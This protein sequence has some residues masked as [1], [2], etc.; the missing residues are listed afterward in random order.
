MTIEERIVQLGLNNKN[1]EKN[2]EQSIRTLDQLDK[3]LRFTG[4]SIGLDKVEGML[5]KISDR[6]SIM[7][8][9]GD[10][11]IR[12]LTNSVMDLV[13][14]MGQLAKS[15]SLDQVN[16][17]FT[18]YGQKTS[19]VQ[20]IM[21]A[22]AK[23][24]GTKFAD[25]AE[26]MDFVNAQL[27][28]LNWFTDETSYNFLDMVNNIGK[29]TSVGQD[30]EKSV[31]AMEGIAT[32]A[33]LSGANASEASRAMYNL[34]QAM[35]VGAVKLMDWKSIENANMATLE[36]KQTALETAVQL[37]T[38]K[39]NADGLYETLE[40]HTFTTEQFN[41]Y[42]QDNWFSKDV[43]MQT[44]SLY[45]DFADELNR[46]TE[47]HDMT[48][49][50]VIRA[51]KQYKE[52]GVVVKGL[53]ADIKKLASAEYDL[54]FRAFAA[55]QEAKTFEDAVNATKD[56]VSTGWMNLFETMFGGYLE[57]KKLWT[58][59]AESFYNIFAEPVNKLNEIFEIAFGKGENTVEKA[60]EQV[61]E[62][63]NTLEKKLA[64]AGRSMKDFEKAFSKVD[65]M[66]LKALVSE[67]GS[68]NEAI[69]QGAVG[70]DLF[71]AILQEMAGE[72]SGTA[73]EV[74]ESLGDLSISL[75]EYRKV[76]M[77]VL[78]GK[79]GNGD[80]RRKALEDLGY[81]YEMI[82]WLAGNLHSYGDGVSDEFLLSLDK[83]EH[84]QKAFEQIMKNAGYT[85][86]EIAAMN[87]LL[88]QSDQIVTD[89]KEGTLAVN[90]AEDDGRAGREL[91]T[92]S[93]MNLLHAFE[94]IQNG[95]G[96]AFAEVFGGIDE[97]GTKLRNLIFRFHDFTESLQMSDEKAK[98]FKDSVA[99]VFRILQQIGNT[100]GKIAS[101]G[102]K[103]FSKVASTVFHVLGSALGI[104][105]KLFSRL[106]NWGVFKRVG[107]AF[108]NIFDG[109]KAPIQL[110]G[111]MFKTYFD[112][113]KKYKADK[114]FD[115]VSLAIGN[116]S[117]RFY[118]A[119]KKFKNFMTSSE[120]SLKIAK[121]V[122]K[123]IQVMSN[124]INKSGSMRDAVVNAFNAVRDAISGAINK[125]VEFGK[126]LL[127]LNKEEGEGEGETFFSKLFSGASAAFEW[128]SNA[129]QTVKKAISDFF[130][131]DQGAGVIKILKN[132]ALAFLGF[133][134]LKG[135]GG[136]FGKIG[137]LF[138]G[139]GSI[140][141]FL[142]NPASIFKNFV[143]GMKEMFGITEQ[144]KSFADD[145]RSIAISIGILALSLKLLA[146]IPTDNISE[147]MGHLT[148]LLAEMIGALA[149]I[150]YIGPGK[151]V[152]KAASSMLM[153][154]GAMLL[155]S[156]S[157][158]IIAKIDPARLNGAWEAL[159]LT[160][161]TMVVVLAA[162]SKIDIN[163]KKL[164]A[165]GAAIMG[166]AVAM[167]LLSLALLVLSKIPSE[168][169]TK[170]W[171]AMSLSL[172][173]MVAA[174]YILGK[175]DAGK[176]LAAG[177]AMMGIAAAVLVLCAALFI[178][179]KIPAEGLTKA[180]EAMSLSLLSMVAALYLLRGV[181]AGKMLAAG[182]AMLM[183]AAAML[184]LSVGLA[185]LSKVIKGNEDVMMAFIITIAVM[186]V[187][188]A[189]LAGIGPIVLAAGAALLLAGAGFAIGALGMIALAKALQMMQGLPLKQLA[190]GLALVGLALI[191]LALGG[192]ILGLAAVGLTIG[193]AALWLFSKG[194]KAFADAIGSGIGMLAEALPKLADGFKAF[195]EV[196]WHSIAAAIV[197]LAAA[198]GALF[199]LQFATIRDGTP[200]LVSLANAMPALAT[201]FSSFENVS[202]EALGKSFVGLAEGIGALIGLTL[203]GENV[204][205]G[206]LGQ[207]GPALMELAPGIQAIGQLS[208]GFGATFLSLAEGVGA[209]IML[210]FV[211]ATVD[212]T[213]L[214]EL[215]A[216]LVNFAPG[217]EA[218][219][220]VKGGLGETFLALSEGVGAL[221]ALDFV[222]ATVDPT[223]LGEL[224]T[225]LI[226]FA[227]GIEA[228]NGV[229]G[230]LGDTFG[231]LVE[232]V[233]ALIMLD[234][235]KATVDPTK[236][237][238]LGTALINFAPGIE[239]INNVEGGIGDTFLALAS[240]VA[241]LIALDFVKATV[242]TTKLGELGTALVNFAPGIEAINNVDGGIGDTFLSLATAIGGLI[243]LEMVDSTVDPTL[244]GSLGGALVELAPGI[245]AF[246]DVSLGDVGTTFLSLATAVNAL[247]DLKMVDSS[248]DPTMLKSLGDAL[249]S[250]AT[251]IN[252]FGGTSIWD[253]VAKF[254]NVADGVKDILNIQA[255][256]GAD[257]SAIKTIGEA[258]PALAQGIASFDDYEVSKKDIKNKFGSV[259]EG[260]E[261][262]LSFDAANVAHVSSIGIGLL[263]ISAALGK[264]PEDAGG[265]ME[266][267]KT[268]ISSGA[269][270]VAQAAFQC[271]SGIVTAFTSYN[272]VWPILGGNVSAGIANGIAANAYMAINAATEVATAIQEAFAAAN[273]IASPSKVFAGY[274]GYL[275]EGLAQGIQAGSND[276]V[277]SMIVAVSPALAALQE[278]LNG[279]FDMEPRITP[280][281]DMSNISAVKGTLGNAFG[282]VYGVSA[283]MSGSINARLRDVERLA[284]SMEAAGQTIN[285]NGDSFTFNIY[286]AEGMDENAIADAVMN[287]MQTRMVRRGVAFG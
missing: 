226:N 135:V 134:A 215:G 210:D 126:K 194:L 260:V 239:A 109:I 83:T 43:L 145:L 256:E 212:P 48:A 247:L 250:L 46:V 25:E 234:F 265:S 252:S 203:V 204:N 253:I 87:D 173:S 274:G 211:K 238:E 122:Q 174:L 61:E 236:L 273:Q 112:S 272:S 218:I 241:G 283:Q 33:A 277:E 92:E 162:I 175:V 164:L 261:A 183:I 100:I 128:I 31:T 184:V 77:D 38:L 223:K 263:E 34:S 62:T 231:A 78:S 171:E 230:G 255:A 121:A 139:I 140:G 110:I 76:A 258:L 131:G 154:A 189:L 66:R 91:F 65:D 35:G 133:K 195:S 20:T 280:V 180:W 201:G 224:G 275:M 2:A 161:L 148:T 199:L 10:Q 54:G 219:N 124:L 152:S 17:G 120:T 279:D 208:G 220:G 150:N 116:L 259:A 270:G 222:K 99:G 159:T 69:R 143:D 156:A 163:G 90:E 94:Q 217:I 202:G 205:V 15:M 178:L 286:P 271:G 60:G 182:A 6:F 160:L 32:W 165:A 96:E 50:E 42:L 4:G 158:A 276:V 111:S 84:V 26:Q 216:A 118:V 13:G 30:L 73:E 176:M 115:K 114:I 157:L 57:A 221:I 14:Q 167:L 186:A 243:A 172:L 37:K 153:I 88:E 268:A 198:V 146:S 113:L 64:K 285:N 242:D 79:Y 36:F 82:Q 85:E 1:F 81:D 248:V 246:E 137:E 232:G 251:G 168:G 193:G 190:G 105:N 71:K 19:S 214:G 206:L 27:E 11:V 56:A 237:G 278:L 130:K 129:F 41:S 74:E 101:V 40:G 22:T 269:M 262:L 93:I 191:P 155:L 144:K 9:A 39:K 209:L 138:G 103:V 142:S 117:G 95:V 127:G 257:P 102:F 192:I 240:A 59:I 24:I 68:L 266:R 125:V 45:G 249:P 207:L 51:V 16:E 89:I 53:E 254:G 86:E 284:S 3:S 18:K 233:G 104:A 281:V 23:D 227:P 235:V 119:T 177:I 44:L 141:E 225:A 21:A 169:L 52:E 108:Q 97:Q 80:E 75:E 28:K 264:L 12:R 8:I 67:Y 166:I 63:A 5:E 200:V 55:A 188:L 282:G 179:S 151:Q 72:S 185:V 49:S 107:R 149:A 7:G 187:A 136:F 228:I 70:A 197:S 181:G 245:K 29:F 147:A 170:A 229:S 213:K 244:L 58:D 196:S 47:A 98:K 132:L 123:I 267:I 106:E 287:R